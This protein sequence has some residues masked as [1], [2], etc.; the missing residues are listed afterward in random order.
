[1]PSS[2]SNSA[3]NYILATGSASVPPVPVVRL[4]PRNF[5]PRE[6][7]SMATNR[8]RRLRLNRT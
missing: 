5:W 7:A 8:G 3:S 2:L 6:L 4:S 1:M